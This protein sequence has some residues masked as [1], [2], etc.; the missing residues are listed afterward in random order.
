MTCLGSCSKSVAVRAREPS[1][2]ARSFVFTTPQLWH[3]I[4]R[5]F[6]CFSKTLAGVSGCCSS[7]GPST[8]TAPRELSRAFAFTSASCSVV[9]M[10][11]PL[12]SCSAFMLSSINMEELED[13]SIWTGGRSPRSQMVALTPRQTPYWRGI[14]IRDAIFLGRKH[15]GAAKEVCSLVPTVCMGYLSRMLS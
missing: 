9:R 12:Q 4:T 13:V 11:L 8:Q 7:S 1:F 6:C 2:P 10:L 5:Y 3:L 15:E 14:C